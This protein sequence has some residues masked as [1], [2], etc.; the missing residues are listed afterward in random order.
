MTFYRAKGTVYNVWLT[1]G[2]QCKTLGGL[3]RKAHGMLV[4]TWRCAYSVLIVVHVFISTMACFRG[5]TRNLAC[6]IG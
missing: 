1:S 4:E 3:H 6:D 5:T 2:L